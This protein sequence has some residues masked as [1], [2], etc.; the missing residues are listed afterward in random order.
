MAHSPD[1][2]PVYLGDGLYAGFDGFHI[3][4]HLGDH[5]SPPVAFLER[6][7]FDS[8]VKFSLTAFTPP[9]GN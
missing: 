7:V 4:L 3:T 6:E 2:R 5:R 8:L 1:V 9:K